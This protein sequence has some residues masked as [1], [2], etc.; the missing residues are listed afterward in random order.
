MQ[1]MK[2]KKSTGF[3][4]QDF[5]LLMEELAKCPPYRGVY[6]KKLFKRKNHGS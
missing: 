6:T 2:G 3:S 5:K 1:L 4:K